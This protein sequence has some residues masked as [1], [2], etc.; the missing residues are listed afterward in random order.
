[1]RAHL[2]N[3]M[4]GMLDYIAQPAA[5]LLAA[6]MLLHHLG[7]ARY[8]VWL[9][10]SAAVGAG[11]VVS[12]GFGDAVIQR[13]ATLRATDDL[14]GIRR[15]VAN[16]LA[17]NLALGGALALTLWAVVPF[18][19]VRITHVEPRLYHDCVWALRIGAALIVV[20]AVES[21]F[22]SSQRAFE[23]YA[24]AVKIGI[25]MRLIAVGL[26]ASLGAEGYG[27][28]VLMI[29]TL[30]L[31][32]LGVAAQAC[33]L[34][35][36]LGPG[37]TW[38]AFDRTVSRQL[39]SFGGFSWLQAVSGVIFS[40]ADRLLLGT[41]LGAS[42]V[43]Y[44]GICVQV[45]QP[46]HGLTSAG[47]HFLFPHLASRSAL[48]THTELGRPIAK[49]FLLNLAGAGVLL[50]LVLAVGPWAI[51]SWIGPVFV[52]DSATLLPEI[53]LSFGLLALNITAH[54]TLMA[55]GR[56]RIV[57]AANMV[58]GGLMLV[59]MTLLIPHRGVQG[60][61]LARLWYG[62]VTCLMYLPLLYLL[63]RPAA[64]TLVV[65]GGEST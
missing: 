15:V 10:A 4:Y 5:M 41:T 6:P 34:R 51:K 52:T 63:R 57:T 27:V 22:I 59:A 64:R 49:A 26:A 32:C 39:T 36:H 60:A 62:P 31:T 7:V 3:S 18:A 53:A 37:L 45:A 35:R 1:M 9:I 50:A 54:Y 12:S 38:P 47:L 16:M 19:A 44:Y 65:M 28:A 20:K 43:A 8:G 24:P 61:A 58:G 21:V 40:Q 25:A 55:F 42:A 30:V 29:G 13:V 2:S 11:T 56:V 23:R 48:E 17:L 14:A 46:I 33:A